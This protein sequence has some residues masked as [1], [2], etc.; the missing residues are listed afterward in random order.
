MNRPKVLNALNGAL[1]AEE[2]IPAIAK[3]APLS[4]KYAKMAIAHSIEMPL[5][6]SLRLE[7]ALEG[8][9]IASEDIK[10]GITAFLEKIPAVFQDK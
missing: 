7:K 6:K 8:L 3:N 10:N 1:L 9:A 4:V 2:L 5:E